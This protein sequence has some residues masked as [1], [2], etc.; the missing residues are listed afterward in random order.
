MR[1]LKPAAAV[2]LCGLIAVGTIVGQEKGQ[3][4]GKT[5]LPPNWNKLDL[6]SEQK[7]KIRKLQEKYGTQIDEL[8]SK[9]R[10]LEEKLRKEEYDVLSDQQ[11]AKLKDIA[12]SK[13]GVVEEKKEKK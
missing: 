13:A 9:I 5:R 6:N 12:A 7:E 2:V 8:K 11:K 10:D 1:I 4:K 3:D